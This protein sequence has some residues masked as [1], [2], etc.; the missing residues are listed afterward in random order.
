MSCICYVIEYFRSTWGEVFSGRPQ[1]CHLW[2]KTGRKSGVASW[3]FGLLKGRLIQNT[4][5]SIKFVNV[6]RLAPSFSKMSY[7]RLSIWQGHVILICVHTIGST[8]SHIYI[9]IFVVCYCW[10][11]TKTIQTDSFSGEWVS[12][13]QNLW[14][15][16]A[17]TRGVF[18]LEHSWVAKT[19]IF[20]LI[21]NKTVKNK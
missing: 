20:T 9:H 5:M 1:R 2:Y 19:T 16:A 10:T 7:Y 17:P 8:L 4:L 18:K 13:L 21:P 15:K 11:S 12:F 14:V 3:K 6:G